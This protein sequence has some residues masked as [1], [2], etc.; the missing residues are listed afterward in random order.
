M[1]DTTEP[2]DELLNSDIDAEII[3]VLQSLTN[4]QC[5][6]TT[7]LKRKLKDDTRRRLHDPRFYRRIDALVEQGLVVR[8]KVG[9]KTT[10]C[11]IENLN[12]KGQELINQINQLPSLNNLKKQN[13]YYTDEKGITPREFGRQTSSR[14]DATKF[15]SDDLNTT[16]SPEPDSPDIEARSHFGV[17]ITNIADENTKHWTWCGYCRLK[18]IGEHPYFNISIQL[19]I[20]Y[21]DDSNNRVKTMPTEIISLHPKDDYNVP[22]KKDKK[23]PKEIIVRLV[24]KDKKTKLQYKS[25][26]NIAQDLYG[27]YVNHFI[28]DETTPLEMIL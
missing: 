9:N 17:R 18:N 23:I 4:N 3:D 24:Y 14:V 12:E 1:A 25:H 13:Q 27:K 20:F 15:L 28:V 19:E 7:D 2:D 21:Q 16:M 22:I 10:L 5:I 8:K 6:N 26:A 11:H